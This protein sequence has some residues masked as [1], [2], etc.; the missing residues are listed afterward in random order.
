[1]G[2]DERSGLTDG[3]WTKQGMRVSQVMTTCRL[4]YDVFNS[5]LFN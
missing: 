1:M 5:Y 2:G 3:I 4:L